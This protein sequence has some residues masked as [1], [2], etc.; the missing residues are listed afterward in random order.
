MARYKPEWM[1]ASIFEINKQPA[2]CSSIP[3]A[4]RHSALGGQASSYEL[5]LDGEWR[6]HW[7]PKPG[8]RVQ[9]FQNPA[10][11]DQAWATCPVPAQWEL[12]GYG[13]PIYAPFHMPPSLRKNDLPNIDPEDNPVGAYRRMFQIPADWQGRDIYLQFD[14]VCSAFYVWINGEFVGYSQ[15]SML[16]AEFH[17]TPYLKEGKNLLAVEVYR[18]SDGSYLENQDMWFLSGIFRSVRLFALPQYAIRDF[19]L[20]S[21]FTAGTDEMED[22][23]ASSLVVQADILLSISD[24]EAS[25]HLQLEVILLD[26]EKELASQ[27]VEIESLSRATQAEIHLPVES[28]RLWSAETPILY[29]VLLILRDD[30]GQVFDV[31]HAR[32]GFRKIEIRDRQLWLNGRSIKIKGVNRHDFDPLTGHTMSLERLRED[33]LIMKRNNINA[34]RCSHYPDD[35]RF[36]DLCDQYGLYVL[37]EA[38]IETH[39]LRDVMRGDMQWLDAMSARVRNMVARDKNHASIIMWS[40]GNESSTDDRFAQL[41]DLVHQLDPSRPVHYEQDYRGEYADVFSMMYASPQNLESIANSGNYK[42]RS[43][44]FSW[45]TVNGKDA[46]GKPLLLCEYAHAMGNSL[47]N[48]DEYMRVFEKYPQCIGGFIWD[49][50]DQAILSTNEKGQVCWCYGGDLGDPYRFSIFG[51]NGILA[52]D[53]SPHPALWTVKKGYQP[54]EF[55]AIDLEKFQ[56]ELIN[57]FRF[58]DLALYD[59]CWRVELEGEPVQSGQLPAPLTSPQRNAEFTIPVKTLNGRGEVWLILSLQLRAGCDWAEAGHEIAWEQFKLPVSRNKYQKGRSELSDLTMQYQ[60]RANQLIIHGS[61]WM[62]AFDRKRGWLSQ[63][64]LNDQPLLKQAL[65]PNL[66]R[67]QIDNDI[68]SAV[69]YPWASPLLLHQYWRVATNRM[70]CSHFEFSVNNDSSYNIRTAWRMPG[71]RRAFMAA[72]RVNADG[73]IVVTC[74]FQPQRDLERMGMQLALADQSWQAS[75]FGLGPQET[76]PDRKLGA[77]VGRFNS[78]SSDLMHQYVR[79]QENGNRSDLRWLNMVRSDGLGLRFQALDD[80]LFCFSAWTCTQDDL[81]NATHIHELPNR[82][83]V[84]LNIDLLQKGVGGD[85][86]VGGSPH[87]Q[88]ILKKNTSF[89]YSFSIQGINQQTKFPDG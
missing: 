40:L 1:D 83:F 10:F 77:R 9:D 51:C 49:F 67:V 73:K 52:A 86:P 2:R 41:T 47:G 5:F 11:D 46:D 62:A 68:S 14:G 57:K 22:L 89:H 58:Q 20:K 44:I 53:R 29:D 63:Y 33:V 23:Y 70:H 4:D 37:D 61:G 72:Y 81:A 25:P 32:H 35:E 65:I 42:V 88:Y 13:V 17:I 36:Y 31:R 39:G 75:W 15:D 87:E 60:N 66:W 38:N 48:F 55:R 45:E 43:G 8:E 30:N 27:A 50:A 78:N 34:V 54:V 26:G 6:F 3:F 82:D 56:F 59:L 19:F 79:P 16:P 74:D 7:A 28:P 18:F 64:W 21:Q 24:P 76:M 12:H 84:T 80:E 85:V 71:S 69:F